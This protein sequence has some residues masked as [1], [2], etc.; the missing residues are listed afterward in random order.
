M[1]TTFR[2]LALAST[3]ALTSFAAMAAE[4]TLVISSWAP[5]THGIN[6]L[7]WPRL[8][9]A[10]EE[11]TD[12]R[13]TAEVKYGLASPPAQMDLIMDGAADMTWIFHGYNPG[14]FVGTK[15]IE[16]PGYEGNAE[17]ASVAY[18]RAHEEFLSELDEHRGVKLVALMTHGPGILHT[19]ADVT[20][21]DQIAG[22]KLRLG[23]GVSG[24][25][26][27]ALGATGIRVP[28]PKV[29][30]TLASGAADGVMMPMEGKAGFKLNEV[31]KNSFTVPGGFYRGSFALI[32]SQEAFDDLSEADRAALETVFGEAASRL[33]GQVWD[34]I[35]A[36]GLQALNDTEDNSLREASAE[37]AETWQT[38]S[39]EIVEDVLAEVSEKGVDAKAAQTFIAKQM[40]AE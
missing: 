20:A 7:L 25:V 18:W 4:T 37:D 14:R 5:P 30:E 28:A 35:D 39:A 38:M 19:D 31:A 11:A 23:G 16:L 12:G 29:Y 22:M 10:M 34:E 24:A 33:A 26:G 3:M 32:M 36:I 21:L 8:T 40:V 2:T 1:K 9:E 6:A 17:A 15:L 27:E 13:V